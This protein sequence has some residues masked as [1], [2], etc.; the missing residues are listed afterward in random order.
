M[1]RTPDL[2][3]ADG[4]PVRRRGSGLKA[5]LPRRIGAPRQ[6]APV[7]APSGAMRCAQAGIGPEGPP[8]KADRSAAADRPGRSAFRRDAMCASARSG[9]KALLPRRIGAPRQIAPVGAPSGAM[10]CAQ[11]GIGPEGPPTKADRSAA[12]DRPGRSAFRRDAM[13]AGARSGLKALLPRRIAAT[14]QIAQVGAPSGA[15]RCAQA[16]IG[17]EGPPTKAD[18]SDAADRPGR[19]AFRRDAMCARRDRA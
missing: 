7:G 1:L 2:V 14:R 15:M 13:C 19:S 16:G 6:I 9:L 4:R 11:A 3:V 17:P 5:L 18:R 10:R 8:T 12:A